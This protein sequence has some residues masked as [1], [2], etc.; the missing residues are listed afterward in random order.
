MNWLKFGLI[1][2]SQIISSVL[3]IFFIKYLSNSVEISYELFYALIGLILL[4][5]VIE[6]VSTYLSLVTEE[7]DNQMKI[8]EEI[9]LIDAILCGDKESLIKHKK[10]LLMKKI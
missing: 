9:N 6:I 5:T 8:N 2:I 10:Q 1:C 4:F 7:R 3:M